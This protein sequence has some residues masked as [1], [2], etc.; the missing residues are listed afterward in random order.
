MFP[1]EVREEEV[2]DQDQERAFIESHFV[3]LQAYV[4]D[5]LA[6]KTFKIFKMCNLSSSIIGDKIKV[7]EIKPILNAYILRNFYAYEDDKV[8][9]I[10]VDRFCTMLL[11]FTQCINK[12]KWHFSMELNGKTKTKKS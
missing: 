3:T 10:I 2:L 9:F 1:K 6:G 4:S 11:K 7:K 12:N 5:P 8:R